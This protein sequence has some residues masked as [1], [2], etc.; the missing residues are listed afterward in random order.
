MAQP[1]MYDPDGIRQSD[2]MLHPDVDDM[3]YPTHPDQLIHPDRQD[4]PLNQDSLRYH[5]DNR[6]QDTSRVKD[7]EDT[8]RQQDN[9]V[10]SRTDGSSTSDTNNS[11]VV[12]TGKYL[13]ALTNMSF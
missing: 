12:R 7:K 10:E 2:I 13:T 1:L 9:V 4:K 6:Q 8:F 11:S 3:I 5:Q